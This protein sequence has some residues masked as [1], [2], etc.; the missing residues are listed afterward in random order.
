LLKV[1][2]DN[3]SADYLVRSAKAFRRDKTVPAYVTDGELI[4]RTED[5]WESLPRVR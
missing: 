4:E 1:T 3:P 2:A 5:R